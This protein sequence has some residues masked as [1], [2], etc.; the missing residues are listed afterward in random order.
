V[1]DHVGLLV[2]ELQRAGLWGRVNVLVTSDHGMTQCSAQRLIR[3]DDCLHPNNY[4]L[5]D[6]APVTALLP[7]QGTHTSPL[8]SRSP[9]VFVPEISIY[10]YIFNFNLKLFNFEF[11]TLASSI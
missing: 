2:S 10:D 6:L 4:T 3:L 11:Q 5:V 1:D 8:L 9:C 7:T